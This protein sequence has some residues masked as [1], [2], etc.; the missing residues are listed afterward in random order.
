MGWNSFSVKSA[1]A[2]QSHRPWDAESGWLGTTVRAMIRK[3]Y[4]F[5]GIWSMIQWN[6]RLTNKEPQKEESNRRRKKYGVLTQN[7]PYF[8]FLRFL[9][10]QSAVRFV[11]LRF[12]VLQFAVLRKSGRDIP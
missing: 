11:N 2:H 10:R 5:T 1:V 8:T 7:R 3:S 6:H 12:L 9:V 4:P